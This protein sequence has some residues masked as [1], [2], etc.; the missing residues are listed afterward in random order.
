MLNNIQ[1]EM[2]NHKEVT[3]IKNSKNIYSKSVYNDSF[4]TGDNSNWKYLQMGGVE[5]H[6]DISS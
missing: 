1:S 3:V 4:V 6:I 5:K 2:I